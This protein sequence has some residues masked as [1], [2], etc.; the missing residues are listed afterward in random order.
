MKV[1]INNLEILQ[2][3]VMKSIL[4]IKDTVKKNPG[5]GKIKK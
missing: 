2:E 5:S 1:L 3:K 4:M